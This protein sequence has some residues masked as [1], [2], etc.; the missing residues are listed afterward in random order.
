MRPDEHD[1]ES[2]RNGRGGSG[3]RIGGRGVTG[4]WAQQGP[5]GGGASRRRTGRLPQEALVCNLGLILDISVGGMRVMSRTPHSGVVNV[6]FRDYP[7]P[8]PLLATVTWSKRAGIFMR[9]MGLRF[10]NVSPQ[11]SSVLTQIASAHRFRRAM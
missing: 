10:E 6:K 1:P 4:P 7:T 9:E 5:Q 11:M 3:A 8:E 2:F